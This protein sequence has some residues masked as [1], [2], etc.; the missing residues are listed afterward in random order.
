VG[1]FQ[2]ER[3]M[4]FIG[5]TPLGERDAK[6]LRALRERYS[7][8]TFDEHHISVDAPR[9]PEMLAALSF[10]RVTVDRRR[11]SLSY[12]SHAAV[13]EWLD[14]VEGQA[15]DGLVLTRSPIGWYRVIGTTGGAA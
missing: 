3:V 2:E 7:T 14:R 8:E 1:A 6:L 11:R 10:L 12:S 4:S 15:V 5:K 9:S 13:A